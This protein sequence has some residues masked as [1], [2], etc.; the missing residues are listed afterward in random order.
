MRICILEFLVGIRNLAIII[1]LKCDEER[2]SQVGWKY[3]KKTGV[4]NPRG[5]KASQKLVIAFF[6]VT[7]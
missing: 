2:L 6:I 3:N 1:V 4:D 5:S 7:T